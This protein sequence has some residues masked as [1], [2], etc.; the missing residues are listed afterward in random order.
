MHAESYCSTSITSGGYARDDSLAIP[1]VTARNN[2]SARILAEQLAHDNLINPNSS[3]EPVYVGKTGWD[4]AEYMEF[5]LSVIGGFDFKKG[6]VASGVDKL[7][8]MVQQAYKDKKFDI[9]IVNSNA[10]A[11]KRAVEYSKM[12]SVF[13]G[14]A[15]DEKNAANAN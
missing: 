4:Q 14:F 3:V 1:D 11:E 13:A 10:P 5:W 12:S 15:E 2:E 6:S 7:R 8:N 9:N